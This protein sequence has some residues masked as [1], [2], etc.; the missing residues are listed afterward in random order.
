LS[1]FEQDLSAD[2][3]EKFVASWT[4]SGKRLRVVI[5][6]ACNSDHIAQAL[7]KHVDFVIDHT[8]PVD[9]KDAVAF[10]RVLYRYLGAGESLELSFDAAKMVSNPY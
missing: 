10:A 7:S 8:T 5:A 6:N 1:L 4:A 2:D 3:L 9:D